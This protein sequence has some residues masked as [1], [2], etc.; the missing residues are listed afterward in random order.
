MTTLE[1]LIFEDGEYPAGTPCEL[2]PAAAAAGLLQGR[3][4]SAAG[5]A[6][7][8]LVVV[9]LRIISAAAVQLPAAGSSEAA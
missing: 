6:A 7:G 5:V 8:D 1:R 9:R 3:L 4:I 2:A